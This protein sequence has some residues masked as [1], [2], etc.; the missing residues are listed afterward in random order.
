MG[1]MDSLTEPHLTSLSPLLSPTSPPVCLHLWSGPR[2]G[3]LSSTPQPSTHGGPQ[4][5]PCL[6]PTSGGVTQ[7]AA[8]AV[9]H[10]LPARLL[11]PAWAH[12]GWLGEMG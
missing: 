2:G 4:R 3:Q 1:Y 12:A 11:S 9:M 7:A 5:Q 6:S 8:G 10:A